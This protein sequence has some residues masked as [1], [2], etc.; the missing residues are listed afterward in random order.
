[1]KRDRNR[2]PDVKSFSDQELNAVWQFVGFDLRPSIYLL[3]EQLEKLD[4]AISHEIFNI[5]KLNRDNISKVMNLSEFSTNT[6]K[7]LRLFL[8]WSL[9]FEIYEVSDQIQNL[10]SE[11]GAELDRRE[12]NSDDF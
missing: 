2:L 9:D 3:S 4:D 10:N 11:I 7:E 12:I 6:L 8:D 1:M 5:R